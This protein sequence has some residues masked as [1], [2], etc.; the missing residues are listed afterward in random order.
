MDD[1][2]I[3]DVWGAGLADPAARSLLML[4]AAHPELALNLAELPVG[5]C[6]EL[7]LRDRQAT[8]G[9]RL[10][11]DVVC[12]DCGERLEVAVSLTELIPA[13]ESPIGTDSQ[14]EVI[15]SLRRPGVL[16]EP[17]GR[18]ASGPPPGIG[19]GLPTQP[20][21][22]VDQENTSAGHRGS[23]ALL[24]WEAEGAVQADDLAVEV[25]VLADVGYQAR[26]LG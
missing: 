26:V 15:H 21:G 13:H 25:V 11:G 2:Q 4:A 16:S 12:P 14:A 10:E 5:R 24:R 17:A 6:N 9:D 19:W 7:L 20:S 18:L 22:G 8:F 1:S 3:L 23:G